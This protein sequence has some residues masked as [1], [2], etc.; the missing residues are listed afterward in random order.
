MKKK[1]GEEEKKLT[2]KERKMNDYK[3]EYYME[4]ISPGVSIYFTI[5]YTN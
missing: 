2:K 1:W 5:S 3:N 4:R